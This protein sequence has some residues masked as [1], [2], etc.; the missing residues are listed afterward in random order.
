[1]DTPLPPSRAPALRGTARAW[2]HHRA[3]RPDHAGQRTSNQPRGLQRSARPQRIQG[4]D[5]SPALAW[6]HAVVRPS[7]CPFLSDVAGMTLWDIKRDT[8][9]PRPMKYTLWHTSR[10]EAQEPL[11]DPAHTRKGYE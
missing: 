2:R 6:A 4:R 11:P 5:L 10:Q 9:N 3:C 7:S 8:E 1:M